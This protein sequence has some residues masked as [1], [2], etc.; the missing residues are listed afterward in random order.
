MVWKVPSN[1]GNFQQGVDEQDTSLTPS[2]WAED[3]LLL[4]AA[5]GS[6]RILGSARSD[7][8]GTHLSYKHLSSARA[9]L[10]LGVSK[11]SQLHPPLAEVENLLIF[12]P[13]LLNFWG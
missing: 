5:P 11:T 7:G 3:L 8:G 4:L 9:G 10:G 2:S 1:P 13:A 12:Q 6:T